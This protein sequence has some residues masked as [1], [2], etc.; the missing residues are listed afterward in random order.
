VDGGTSRF[1]RNGV[2]YQSAC[3]NCGGQVPYPTT[4]GAWQTVKPASAYCNLG[5]LKLAFNLAGVAGNVSSA[6]NGVPADTAGCVPLTVV[7]TDQVRN[8]T[9]YIWNFGDNT[10]DF[11]PYRADTGYTRVHT[12]NNV[13]TYQ[14]MLVAINPASC[15]IRD[16]SYISIR[17]SDLI[18]NLAA[19][20]QKL[21]GCNSLS[22][23]FNNL[24]PVTT[25]PF[26]ST[27]F[28]WDFGD[29]SPRVTTGN[30][31]VTHT[32]PN[33]GPYVVKLILNDTAFCNHP[34]SITLDVRVAERTVA[35]FTTEPGGCSPYEAEFTNTSDG[36]VTY[37]WNFGSFFI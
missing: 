12:Y 24:T 2:I 22:Y 9:E 1:D 23:Q 25:R 17:V 21:G 34:D 27:S 35:R 20:Y 4:A 3:A 11:G 30:G 7:F 14:V 32:F 15:N 5:M 37:L 10:G 26:T 28:I 19:D 36:G 31:P 8:A 18:A 13:G 16:T 6:I 33:P 29:G